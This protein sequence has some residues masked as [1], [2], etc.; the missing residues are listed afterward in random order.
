MDNET[1]SSIATETFKYNKNKTSLKNSNSAIPPVEYDDLYWWLWWVV[2]GE[3][4]RPFYRTSWILTSNVYIVFT[5]ITYMLFLSPLCVVGGHAG[6]QLFWTIEEIFYG[7]ILE[8][9]TS[10]SYTANYKI[11][12][13]GDSLDSILDGT[14][15]FLPNHQGSADI[16]TC[17]NIFASRYRCTGKLTWIMDY[18]FKF[19]HFGIV[20]WF[21][22]DFF[23]QEGKEHRSKSLEDLK[24]HLQNSFVTKKR[25]CLILFPEGGF[26]RNRKLSNQNF[27]RKNDLPVLEHCTLPRLGALNSVIQGLSADRV[28]KNKVPCKSDSTTKSNIKFNKIVDVTIA[29]PDGKPLGLLDISFGSKDSLK[30]HV[31]YK[32][33]DINELPVDLNG[34]RRWMYNIYL[35]K[36]KL[37]HN[38]YA[39]GN[40][41]RSGADSNLVEKPRELLFDP[42]RFI[43]INFFFLV[44]TYIFVHFGQILMHIYRN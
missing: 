29:Y 43:L 17:M 15:L 10:W 25:Q 39:T 14:I 4:F 18:I 20:S 3:W 1:K 8:L 38:F 6:K 12:E 36:E 19:T 35:E 22:D 24:D 40:F 34:M 5:Y 26:L 13:S 9:L 23:I 32:I 16:P 31:H 28:L 33:Y 7:W 2:T 11:I 27:A 41:P 44:S 21:H 37:L 30:I 42:M